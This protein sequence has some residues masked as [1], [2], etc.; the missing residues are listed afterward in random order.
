[1]SATER[2]LSRRE[3]LS[4]IEGT[5]VSFG[6]L[7]TTPWGFLLTLFLFGLPALAVALGWI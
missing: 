5:R 3:D 4:R 1:M 6:D 7:L 2:L